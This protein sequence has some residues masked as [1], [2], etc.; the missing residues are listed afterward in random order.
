MSRLSHGISS[1]RADIA[2]SPERERGRSMCKAPPIRILLVDDFKPWR[3]FVLTM[4]EKEPAM[5]VVGT[6]MD[7]REAVERAENLQPDLILMDVSLPSLN[8]IESAR[9]ITRTVGKAK[10]IFL[11]QYRDPVVVQ[12]AIAAGG[13]G[14][15]VKIDAVAELAQAIEAVA[16]GRRYF[17]RGLLDS[18]ISGNMNI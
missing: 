11:T 6:A 8:G 7:G 18:D 14:Y 16:Q 13:Q 17:S 5:L 12:S 9:Q 2:L 4:L 15:V 10:I 3:S 1:G